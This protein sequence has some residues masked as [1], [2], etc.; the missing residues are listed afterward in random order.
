MADYEPIPD[1]DFD[2]TDLDQTVDD[3]RDQ[4]LK[5]DGET[6]KSWMSRLKERFKKNYAYVINYLAKTSKG[7]VPVYLKMANLSEREAS[8]DESEE[9]IDKLFSKWD[10]KKVFHRVDEYGV[11][12]VS[13]QRKGGKWWRLETYEDLEVPKFP[14]TLKKLFIRS[15]ADDREYEECKEEIDGLYPENKLPDTW[16]GNLDIGWDEG[17][18]SIYDK[19]SK[20][21]NKMDALPAHLKTLLGKPAEEILE[22]GDKEIAANEEQLQHIEPQVVVINKQIEEDNQSITSYDSQL[23]ELNRQA[24][25]AP[26]GDQQERIKRERNKVIQKKN[27]A[28]ESRDLKQAHKR[29]LQ[30]Q[31]RELE[32]KEEELEEH[33]EAIEEKLPL[34]ERVKRVFKKYGFTVTAVLT[35]VGIT[36]GVIV[37]QLKSGLTSVAKGVGNGLKTLGEKLGQILPGMIGAIASFIFRT[38]G[39]VVGFLAKNAWL[40]IVAA[41]VYFVEKIKK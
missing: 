14:K 1:T 34:R 39:E 2:P 18:L 6:D 20:K 5:Q 36:I 9:N 10:K 15:T 26:D 23:E 28:A 30:A 37:S 27:E 17:K 32:A 21:W 19:A 31:D 24:N 35:A 29:R 12:E 33:Q 13:L 25:D 11:T 38:A 40:L 3:E 7:S 41:V 4:L 22:E 8:R 16:N